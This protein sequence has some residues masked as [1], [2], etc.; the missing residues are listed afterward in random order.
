MRKKDWLNKILNF[1]NKHLRYYQT[2]VNISFIYTFGSLLG[3][4]ML[5]QII[6]GFFLSMFYNSDTAHAWLSIEY[7][8]MREINFGWFVRNLHVN[9]VSFMFF[10]YIYI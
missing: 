4:C 9:V 3:V 5:L 2:P 8:I 6:S 7:D 1:V 10:F